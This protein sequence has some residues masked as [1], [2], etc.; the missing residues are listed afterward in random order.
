MTC[1]LERNNST[2]SLASWVFKDSE[3]SLTNQGYI[4]GWLTTDSSTFQCNKFDKSINTGFEL[5]PARAICTAQIDAILEKLN[6]SFDPDPLVLNC[7]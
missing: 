2:D 7:S 3:M 6:E 4:L 5:T 1:P